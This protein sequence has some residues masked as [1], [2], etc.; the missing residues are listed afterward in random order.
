MR[1]RHRYRER[2]RKREKRKKGGGGVRK[3][4]IM[5]KWVNGRGRVSTKR[6]GG[7]ERGRERER[8]REEGNEGKRGWWGE[9][10]DR[11]RYQLSLKS[12]N[13]RNLRDVDIICLSILF[14]PLL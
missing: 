10:S 6:K 4:E 14:H 8:E 12:C 7:R 1:E 2:E 5:R 11:N 9:S 3:R 13:I